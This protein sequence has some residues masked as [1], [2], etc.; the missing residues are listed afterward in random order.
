MDISQCFGLNEFQLGVLWETIYGISFVGTEILFLGALII[1]LSQLLG[2]NVILPSIAVY[3]FLHFRKPIPETIG[4]IFGSYT[5]GIIALKK[6]N[7]FGGI[8]IHMGVAIGM[9]ALAIL[10]HYKLMS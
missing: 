2:R 6:K 7:L 5:L 4:S 9:N 8:I 10:Q 3:A 1:G